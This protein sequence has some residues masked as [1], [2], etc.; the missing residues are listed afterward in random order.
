MTENSMEVPQK[1]KNRNTIWSSNSTTGYLPKENENTKSKRYVHLY[2]YCSII[3]NGQDIEATQVSVDRWMD[4]ENV[5][6]I[7]NGIFLSH[8]KEWSLAIHNN[9]NGP[10]GYYAKYNVSHWKTNTMISLICG[11]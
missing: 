9:M 2:V 8:K 11:I 7:Y 3:Y 5:V 1:V 6:Y 10:R 4:K